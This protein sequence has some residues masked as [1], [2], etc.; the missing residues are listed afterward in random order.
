MPGR[1]TQA[2]TQTRLTGITLKISRLNRP[3]RSGESVINPSNARV[4]SASGGEACCRSG[5]QTLR[6]TPVESKTA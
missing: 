2:R 4:S 3:I 6:V 1:S 5:D